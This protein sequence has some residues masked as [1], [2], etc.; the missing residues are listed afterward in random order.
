MWRWRGG[1]PGWKA[2]WSVSFASFHDLRSFMI[3]TRLTNKQTDPI[4]QK[5]SNFAINQAFEAMIHWLKAYWFYM[6]IGG[7]YKVCGKILYWL[8]CRAGCKYS[9]HTALGSWKHTGFKKVT[10]LMSAS[11]TPASTPRAS[12]LC[13]DIDPSSVWAAPSALRLQ[14]LIHH[15]WQDFSYWRTFC[16]PLCHIAKLCR[17][18]C[19]LHNLYNQSINQSVERPPR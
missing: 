2:R 18:W 3:T 5:G 1:V 15:N 16:A 8:C 4:N 19:R 7:E 14:R 17:I 6:Y 10:D 13:Q 11:C 12:T 9:K